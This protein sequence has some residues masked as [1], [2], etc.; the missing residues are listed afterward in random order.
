MARARQ[1]SRAH[2]AAVG[3]SIDPAER[4]GQLST[5]DR[6]LV[7][8]AKALAL[9]ATL[10]ILD[11]PTEALTH[12]ES[13]RL[14]ENISA[15]REQGTAVVY[16]SHRLPEVRR[17]ADRI[18]VLRDGETRGTFA[19][20]E[21]S[22]G[23]ILRLII[24]R[25][26]EQVFPAKR[27][28]SAPV[29]PLL[30]VSELSGTGFHD[31]SLTVAP[32]EIVGL[33]GIEGNGQRPFLRALAGLR[34][35]RGEARLA[36]SPL[37][38]GQPARMRKAGVIH[39]PGDRHREGV[40]LTLSVRDN[41]SL[42][43][44]GDLAEAG[45]VRSAR[46]E[47]AVSAQI[48]RLGIRTPSAETLVSSLSGGNQQKVLFAR[49][50]LAAPR[51]L[52]ADEPTRGV[53]AGARIDL[54]QVMREAAA[55]N[56][57]VI[58]LSSDAVELQGLCD[59]VL[60]FSGGRIVRQ[61]EGDQINE[62]NITGAAVTSERRDQGELPPGAERVLRL[63]RFVAGDYLPSLV[64]ALLIIGLGLYTN[65]SNARFLAPYNLHTTL[66]LASALAFASLGQ[67]VVLLVGGID[68]SVG[69][70][71]GVVVV[72]TSF[73]WTTGQ[74]VGDLVAG[75]VVVIGVA[76]VVGLTIGLLVRAARVSAVLATLAVYIVL[77]GVGL[78]LRPQ[79][80]GFLSASVIDAINTSV[81]WLPVALIVAIAVT[82]LAEVALRR[83][84][85]GLALRAVG[86][87]EARA[88]RLGARV[89]L[90]HI[91]A[92]LLCSLFAAAGGVMLAGQLGVGD[93]DPTVSVTYTLTSITAVILGG[94]SIFG[95]RGSF[96]GAFLGAV[97]LT[98]VVS[99]VTFLQLSVSWNYWLP[100]IMILVGAGIFSRAR[101][102]RAALMGTNEGA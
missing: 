88:Y 70:L 97:L 83:S 36:G 99:A 101:G 11:E 74:G 43:A 18:T 58:V 90:T 31:V 3:A 76:L 94:A 44:L 22:E 59:R 40:I 17:I 21:V 16:I 4:V 5:A 89:N 45:F 32:G 38:L 67:L 64:L 92:Y 54:Y 102:G 39:L 30:E 65:T 27:T 10:L 2:L 24:G 73:F 63:R 81:G 69:P 26:V 28:A 57:G 85:A 42:L 79:Q 14:F 100:G 72:V 98:E 87:D 37:S 33:A 8:I 6:Q 41:V 1:W 53:D 80:A 29:A 93:G 96:I 62:E 71:M 49:A 66:L 9:E 77:Q 95:G 52:L 20:A 15:I 75:I 13:E 68:L 60:V 35:A 84:R 19:A 7:E 47:A 23:D 91:A 48:D 25:A 86:S 55:Q 82:V 50:L 46:E 78:L 61:L 12:V 56:R 34:R 51:L